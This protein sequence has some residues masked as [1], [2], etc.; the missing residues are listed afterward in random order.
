[1]STALEAA[2]FLRSL[3]LTADIGGTMFGDRVYF[4][5][6]PQDKTFPMVV[7]DVISRSESPTQ[8]KG[9]AVDEYRFQVDVM[10][11]T[12]AS[13]SAAEAAHEAAHAV[14]T[15]LTRKD[16]SALGS[17]FDYLFDTVQEV[18]HITDYVPDYDV[19]RVTNDYLIRV[20]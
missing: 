7:F 10:A 16:N 4:S 8:D 15:V 19:Y 2:R 13:K 18:N 9:S 6:A 20:K 11:K 1:M 14:R 12:T 3:I 17:E 5:Q